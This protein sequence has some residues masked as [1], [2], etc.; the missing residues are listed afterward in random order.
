MYVCSDGGKNEKSWAEV[1][2]VR[3]TVREFMDSFKSL[4]LVERPENIYLE[5]NITEGIAQVFTEHDRIIV[6]EDDIVTS[7][8]YLQYMNEAFELYKDVPRVMH[9]SGFTNLALEDTPFY[10]EIDRVTGLLKQRP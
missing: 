1:K 9:V 5:R 4:T 3:Q 6:L 7:P 8:Y 2:E 10:K